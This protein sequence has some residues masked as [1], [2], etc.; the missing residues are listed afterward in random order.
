MIA[1]DS[2]KRQ[3]RTAKGSAFSFLGTLVA[4]LA[5]LAACSAPE[6]PPPTKPEV[7]VSKVV[8]K[9]V[10]LY[11][12]WVGSTVGMVDASI[13]SKVQGYLL[14]QEYL[15]GDEVKS[16]DLLFRID[17]RQFKAALDATRGQLDVAKA[18]L[19]KAEIDVRRYTP[20]AKRGAVSQQELD[21]A[22][23][24]RAAGRAKV[25][26]AQAN[27]DQARLNLQWT[28]IRAPLQGIAG[29]ATVQVGDLVNSLTELTVISQVDPIKVSVPI[30]EVEYLAFSRRRGERI[31]R[32]E[33]RDPA[34]QLILADGTTYPH[35]GRVTSTGRA[36]SQST[37][38]IIVQGVFPNPD[39][40]LRPGQ[41]AKVRAMTEQRK[42]ALVVPQRAIQQ[43]QGLDQVAVV[44]DDDK[45]SLVQVELGPRTGEDWII[46]KGVRA[47]QRVIVEGLQKARA[48]TIVTP[49]PFSKVDDKSAE[50][51]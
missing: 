44:G 43:T 26:A 22:I 4:G 31:A 48:G 30:S 33:K 7:L 38:T 35:A 1:H 23:Q 9:D 40:L 6:P 16:G 34:L 13:R 21:N 41:F 10:E 19:G 15:D 17:P 2:A 14:S 37:G 45:V 46:E 27:V 32:G 29:I 3:P 28:E 50:A 39:R 8:A 18:I 11:T 24:A 5:L 12:E 20:L 42:G 47:G 51:A 49:K 25:V 36:I